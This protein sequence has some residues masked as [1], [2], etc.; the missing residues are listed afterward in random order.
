ML[1]LLVQQQFRSCEIFQNAAS[2]QP[3]S[4]ISLKT[5]NCMVASACKGNSNNQIIFFILN[6]EALLLPPRS[7]VRS[8]FGTLPMAANRTYSTRRTVKQYEL[9]PSV[10][11]ERLSS[12]RM[13]VVRFACGVRTR[14]LCGEFCASVRTEQ[15]DGKV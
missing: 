11:T 2:A 8:S 5:S 1:F 7:M 3:L 13:T 15:M 4:A 12:V 10:R 14:R 6:R 9:V